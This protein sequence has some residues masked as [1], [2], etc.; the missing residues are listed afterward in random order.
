MKKKK[1]LHAKSTLEIN[2]QRLNFN[3]MHFKAFSIV[4]VCC[5][6][7]SEKKKKLN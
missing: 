1:Y 4:D 5:R 7:K 2:I 6:N 3:E